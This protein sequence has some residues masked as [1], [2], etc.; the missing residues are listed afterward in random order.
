MTTAA[1]R[2]V[3]QYRSLV[4]GGGALVVCLSLLFAGIDRY[5]SSSRAAARPV[6]AP[7]PPSPL[8]AT[9]T[10]AAPTP[11]DP[12]R[13]PQ[14]Q[15]RPTAS[16]PAFDARVHGLWQ[17]IVED[18][19]N[20]AMPFFFPLTAYEQVKALPDP[21]RDWQQRLVVAYRNDVH[22]LH[23]SLG[24]AGTAVLASIDVPDAQATWINPGIETNK[25]GYFRVYGTTIHY[26]VDGAKHFFSVTSLISWRGE[27]YV[28]HLHSR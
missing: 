20:L 6:V 1:H 11:I 28:V 13:L 12:G 10:T 23:L 15:D 24:N 26:L 16:G 3:G 9:T 21:A 2:R 5:S 7:V 25:I 19:P 22:A 27:W 8:A 14:T 4:F 18:D 17:A